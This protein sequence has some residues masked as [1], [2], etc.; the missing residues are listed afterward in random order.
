ML[1]SWGLV[2]CV[3]TMPML[4]PDRTSQALVTGYFESARHLPARQECGAGAEEHADGTRTI[5]I[6]FDPP[7]IQFVIAVDAVLDGQIEGQRVIAYTTHH[8]GKEIFRMG[9]SHPYLIRLETDGE[10]NLIPR[11]QFAALA[12]TRDGR[13]AIPDGG[14][15]R[16]TYWLPCAA[17]AMIRPLEFA[18][19]DPY[20]DFEDIGFDDAGL[21][22]RHLRREQGRVIVTHGVALDDIVPVL[23]AA[24]E[25]DFFAQCEDR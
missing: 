9:R 10:T 14:F 1:C 8:W 5:T 4:D 22:D 16:G 17:Q 3:T 19:H 21:E 24:D 7:P 18:P 12:R 20:S 25:D 15:F 23:L 13:W 2:G 11:N 6:C